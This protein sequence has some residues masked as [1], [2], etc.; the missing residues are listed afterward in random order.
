MGCMS[1]KISGL[2]LLRQKDNVVTLSIAVYKINIIFVSGFNG[3]YKSM[4]RHLFLLSNFI[5][6][7]FIQN[8]KLQT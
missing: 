4:I 1:G 2:K 3:W 8:H 6:Y 7:F 5:F